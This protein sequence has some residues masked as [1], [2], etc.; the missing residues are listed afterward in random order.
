MVRRNGGFIGTDGL[1]APDPPTDVTGTGGS[2]QVSVAFTAP[3]DA[4]TS[5]ITGFVVQVSTDGTAYSA[6]SNTG[7]SSPIVVTGLT[8]GTAA[9]AKVWAINSHGTSAPSDASASFTPALQRGLMFGGF[10]G[11]SGVDVIDFYDLTTTGNSTD[12]GDCSEAIRQCS[13][14]GGATRILRAGGQNNSNAVR[15]HIKYVTAATTGNES[16][17]GN[18]SA[19]FST[20]GGCGNST[21]ALFGGGEWGGSDANT[22]EYVTIASTGNGTDFGDLTRTHDDINATASATRGVFLGGSSTTIDYVTIASTGNASDFG[23]LLRAAAYLAPAASATRGVIAGNNNKQNEIQYITIAST[24]NASDSG[25]LTT[26]RAGAFGVSNNTIAVFSG[27]ESSSAAFL[28][29]GEQVTIAS[30]GNATDF[31][32]LTDARGYAHSGASN[33]HGGIA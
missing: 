24:G 5:S 14:A 12:F 22:I 7:T 19:T 15:N 3:T 11:S 4:G 10:D 9:T 29:S 21:R 27:G 25:D 32:T 18:L 8:N 31:G 6:G 33:C 23:D 20:G 30:T 13:A 1:D 28:T 2:E 26:G 17:F 16:D